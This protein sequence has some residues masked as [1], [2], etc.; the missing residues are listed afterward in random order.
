[1]RK[2]SQFRNICVVE[3][4]YQIKWLVENAGGDLVMHFLSIAM[5]MERFGRM[6]RGADLYAVREEGDGISG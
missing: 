6:R 5:F 4:Y 1:M 2:V 3:H